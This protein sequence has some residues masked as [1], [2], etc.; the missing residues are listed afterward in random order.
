MMRMQTGQLEALVWIA[1]LGSF[2]AAASHLGLTQPTISMRIRELERLLDTTLFDR[3]GNRAALSEAGRAL[4]P[5]AERIVG[6]AQQME[7]AATK[8]TVQRAPIRIGAADTFALTCLPLLLSRVE[9]LF[10]ELR[11]QLVVDYSANL[12][13]RLQRAELDVAI[14][15]APVASVANNG[16]PIAAERLVHLPLAWVASP[17]LPLPSAQPLRPGDLQSQ[18]ILTN[19]RPSHLWSSIVGWFGEAGLPERVATCNSL[20]IIARLAANGFGAA[21]LPTSILQTELRT[22]ALRI[23]RTE[24]A[25]GGHDLMLAYRDT[26]PD[27][28]REDVCRAVREAVRA[29]GLVREAA[30]RRRK[31]A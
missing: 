21:L 9:Q 15:T 12:N 26:G 17:R 31:A 4:V 18:T 24:P 25:M 10:P 23:C 5:Y 14:L 3:A 2:R 8:R 22:G 13:A 7:A 16:V 28:A 19:P 6:L 20:T 27:V 11:V 29:G 30:K 1:R